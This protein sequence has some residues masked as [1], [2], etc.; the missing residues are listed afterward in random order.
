MPIKFEQRKNIGTGF[1]PSE[2][3]FVGAETGQESNIHLDLLGLTVVCY[4]LWF[5]K[6]KKN[7]YL[8]FYYDL[9]QLSLAKLSFFGI[10]NAAVL[11]KTLK[12]LLL[13]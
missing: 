12:I 11:K 6:N 3:V 7:F 1:K 9:F 8:F 13:P 4:S 5:N 2:A 10:F